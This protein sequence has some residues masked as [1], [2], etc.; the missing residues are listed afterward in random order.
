[1]RIGLADRVQ[2]MRRPVIHWLRYLR[3]LAVEF[4]GSLAVFFGVWWFAAIVLWLWY[5]RPGPEGGTLT[6]REALY[7]VFMMLPAQT[8]IP[9]PASFGLLA[10]FYIVPAVGLIIVAEGIVRFGVVLFNRK[11]RLQEWTMVE[12][13]SLANHIIVCGGGK[14][15]YR[16]TLELERLKEQVVVIEKEASTVFLQDLQARGIPVVLADA[17]FHKTLEN[18]NIAKAKA[19]IATTNDDLVNLEAA[20]GA[21]E[22][23]PKIRVVLRLFD[24]TLAKKIEGSFAI[25]SISTSN[26]S[27]P[28]F[29]AAATNRG[30]FHSFKIDQYDLHLADL[31]VVE[32]CCLVGQT[33]GQIT[34]AIDFTVV[35]YRS[36]TVF[37]LHPNPDIVLKAGDKIIVLASL[38]KLS[39]I[40]NLNKK[41]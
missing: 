35:L 18:A 40:E 34:R 20:L 11:L 27:A 15:G 25:P 24:D 28:A 8:P 30:V 36:P 38:E 10:I 26:V 3:I 21:K 9:P 39:E 14:V 19:L 13:A 33:I 29:V 4:R 7:D 22:M 17:R 41:P 23:N 16:V 1:M 6:F 32:G 5:V 31:T 12:C 2:Q 37:D